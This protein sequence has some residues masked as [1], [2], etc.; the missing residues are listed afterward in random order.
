ME[1]EAKTAME[2]PVNSTRRTLTSCQQREK[3]WAA[4]VSIYGECHLL[5]GFFFFLQM[6]TEEAASASS[7]K[8]YICMYMYI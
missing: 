6:P 7:Y 1:A 2:T 5:E 8:T 3:A 4:K